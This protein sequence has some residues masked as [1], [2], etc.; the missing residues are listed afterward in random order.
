MGTM[1]ERFAHA[2]LSLFEPVPSDSA[3]SLLKTADSTVDQQVELL[4]AARS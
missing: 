2:D 1:D 3:E 4:I